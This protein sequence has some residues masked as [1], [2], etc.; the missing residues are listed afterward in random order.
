MS[1]G[2]DK[3]NGVRSEKLEV[4]RK[5]D[6]RQEIE[7]GKWTKYE[8][9]KNNKKGRPITSDLRRLFQKLWPMTIP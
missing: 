8:V 2:R 6:G 7:D 4:R 1:D 9:G 5:K 3:K